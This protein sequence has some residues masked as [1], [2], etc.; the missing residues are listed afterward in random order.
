MAAPSK[1]GSEIVIYTEE[2][3]PIGFDH[4][5]YLLQE[6]RT[7]HTL[8]GGQIDKGFLDE[9]LDMTDFLVVHIYDDQVRGFACVLKKN[10]KEL[11]DYLYIDLICNAAFHKMIT[12]S[13]AGT[14]LFS[15][16]HMLSA[17]EDLARSLGI[18][19]I[20]LNALDHVITYYFHLGY[21]FQSKILNEEA[22]KAIASKLRRAM[23]DGYDEEAEQILD[24][25]IGRYYPGFYSESKQAELAT[26]PLGERKEMVREDGVPMLLHL[27]DEDDDI[28]MKGG[29]RG[30]KSKH[31]R[32]KTASRKRTRKTRKLRH[33]RKK[34]ASRKSRRRK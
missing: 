33:K 19:T 26:K 14:T 4:F 20:K 22:Q 29:K 17:I 32:K 23:K 8:C 7:E 10:S 9:T 15:G 13:K 16:K 30:G 34:T 18:K 31:K 12:R 28:E 2:D 24:T 3:N 6:K 25:I 21:R 27:D 5:K 1:S 11:G